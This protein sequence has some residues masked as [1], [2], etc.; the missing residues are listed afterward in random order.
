MKQKSDR[1]K[2]KVQ[3]KK[4]AALLFLA[5]LAVICLV[6]RINQTSLPRGI[7]GCR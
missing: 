7:S 6:S 4:A 5:M 3:I 2:R 1:R